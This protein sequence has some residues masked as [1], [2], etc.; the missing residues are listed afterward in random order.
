MG[1]AVQILLV[2]DNKNDA[3]LTMRTLQK[4]HVGNKVHWV[5][6]GAEAVD[7]LFARGEYNHRNINHIPKV[8]FLD[9]KLPK[10]DGI[11]VL[12]EIRSSEQLK[13]L[14]VVMLTS[15]KE[16]KDMIKSYDLGVNSYVVKPIDFETFTE[17]IDDL[18]YYWLVMNEAPKSPE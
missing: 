2:E 11:E 10:M 4:N 8:V 1:E 14:P 9:L 15:S 18:G 5:Q 6:D 13:K 7:F 16:E 17:A 12:D 3:E